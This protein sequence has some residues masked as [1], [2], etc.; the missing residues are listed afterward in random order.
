MVFSLKGRDAYLQVL[1]LFFAIRDEMKSFYK[2][3]VLSWL[4]EIAG[5]YKYPANAVSCGIHFVAVGSPPDSDLYR[6]Q[7]CLHSMSD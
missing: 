7:L 4:V 6:G 1:G 3:S 5:T 2:Y